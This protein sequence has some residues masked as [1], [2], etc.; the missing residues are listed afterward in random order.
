MN[1]AALPRTPRERNWGL[2]L[3]RM[4]S[5]CMIVVLHLLS[6]GGVLGRVTPFSWGFSMAW[7]LEAG[8]LCAVNCYGLI[9]GYVGGAGTFRYG[10]YL[11]HWLPVAFWS[12]GLYVLF[13]AIEPGLG[14]VDGLLTSFFPVLNA[15]YWYFTAYTV[16]FFLTPF[17]NLIVRH[18]DQIQARNLCLTLMLL[19]SVLPS[20]VKGDPFTLRFGYSP[21]WLIA[22]Y[23]IGGCLKKFGCR[24]V[25]PPWGSLLVFTL[26]VAATWWGKLWE[27]ASAQ[28]PARSFFLQYTAPLMLLAGL[29][30]FHCF[31]QLSIRHRAAVGLI[32]FFAPASFGVYLIHTHPMVWHVLL[33]DCMVPFLTLSAPHYLALVVAAAVGIF[34]VCACAEALRLRLFRLM[35]GILKHRKEQNKNG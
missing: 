33:R 7:L 21:L 12:V 24:G 10:S 5:M 20:F 19:F 34:L 28:P 9:S 15:E 17:L 16:V 11:S 22:L 27:T 3:L 29:A 14:S 23:L 25:L 1:A 4:V 2:D 8:A 32:G 6:Q 13:W 30:L 26:A 31:R 35:G 18:I